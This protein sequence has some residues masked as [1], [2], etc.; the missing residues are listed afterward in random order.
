MSEPTM[1]TIR[2]THP[3]TRETLEFM[4][5]GGTVAAALADGAKVINE[6]FRPSTSGTRHPPSNL[7]V[8]TPDG[9]IVLKKLK[10]FENPTAP[11]Q[12]IDIP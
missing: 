5:Q 10:E 9:K 2:V 12:E 1:F 7:K 11:Q 3:K 8:V 4:G 6:T